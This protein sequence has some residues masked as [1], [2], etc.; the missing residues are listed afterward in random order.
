[1][2]FHI[3]IEGRAEVVIA[4]GDTA[5]AAVEAARPEFARRGID[6]D[7]LPPDAVISC[8]PDRHGTLMTTEAE[9]GLAA[10]DRALADEGQHR[11]TLH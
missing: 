9:A 11:G 1:M 5:Q 2:K 7:K 4:E 8:L 6:L 3:V 10:V